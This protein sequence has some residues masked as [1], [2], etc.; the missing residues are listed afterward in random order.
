MT[1][2]RPER[3]RIEDGS[4]IC[5]NGHLRLRVTREGRSL[6]LV[7]ETR[8]VDQRWGSL[9]FSSSGEDIVAV[10][11]DGVDQAGCFIAFD[12]LQIAEETQ[13]VT[14]HG[15]LGGATL[16]LT[17]TLDDTS[18]WCQLRLTA[19]G[20]D[21]DC[22]RL[23]QQW[24]LLPG[25]TPPAV[26]WPRAVARG[27]ALACLPAAFVQDGPVFAALVAEPDDD[28]LRPYG[29]EVN[30]ADPI[31]IEYGLWE[32][33]PAGSVQLV[34]RLG[35]DARALPERGFQQV[36][37]LLGSRE[38]LAL[39]G[40]CPATPADGPLPELPAPVDVGE[41]HPFVWEGTVDT[42]AAVVRRELAAGMAGDWQALE[43]GLCWLDRLCL[44][45]RTVGAPGAS[46]P[47]AVPGAFGPEEEWRIAAPWMPVLLMQAFKLTG[48][49]EYAFR[50]QA[51]LAALP[52][53]TQA[54]V[55]GHLRPAFGD[56]YAQADYGALV[57]L[58]GPEVTAACF[59]PDGLALELAPDAALFR[60]VLDGSDDVYALTIN[61]RPRGEFAA[62]A[63]SAGI[64]FDPS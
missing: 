26:C 4:L 19:A 62:A 35:L 30:T 12:P 47:G 22:R 15:Q 32:R 20:V 50:A 52:A 60:L 28:D 18:T 14:L 11:A 24:R 38:E 17:A 23:T 3:R 40:R 55:L 31:C 53:E 6:A 57:S 34:Y 44:H 8:G 49:P 54:V 5:E 29:L 56:L 25:E 42:M 51:A 45:Q 10:D 37:R 63:L 61:G 43:R 2:V 16:T 59:T 41:W 27:E 13:G 64:D 21:G 7:V 58:C 9:A 33:P 1:V 39:A 46:T 36:A 48:I